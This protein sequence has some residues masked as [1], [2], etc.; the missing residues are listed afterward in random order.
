[1]VLTHFKKFPWGLDQ[2][3]QHFIHLICVIKAKVIKN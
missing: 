1:M 2:L 3:Q